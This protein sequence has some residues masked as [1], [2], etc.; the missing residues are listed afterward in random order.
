MTI[1]L[2]PLMGDFSESLYQLG[3]AEKESFLKIEE[4]V[5]H[6]I[7]K[8]FLLRHG[9]DLISRAK[10]MLKKKEEPTLFLQAVEAYAKGLG[11]DKVRYLSFLSMFEMAAHYGQAFPELKGMLPGCT[12][13]FQ[14]KDGDITHTRLFDFPLVDLFET[15]SRLYYWKFEGMPQVLNFSCEGLAPLFIQAIHESGMSFSLHHKPGTS[16]HGDG[17]GI[18]QIIFETMF[19]AK[20][21]NDFRKGIKKRESITKWGLLFSEKSGGVFHLDIDGPSQRIESFNLNETTPLIFT[22]IPLQ[23]DEGKNIDSYMRF[24]HMRQEW[25]KKRLETSKLPILD[26]VTHVADDKDKGFL[27][28]CGT[29]ATVGA[30][31]INQTQGFIELK[32]GESALT[33][34][35]G[36]LRFNL[37]EVSQGH[38]SKAPEKMSAF[39]DAWKR[40]ARAQSY[41]DQDRLDFAYHELQ[42]AIELM[43]NL[44]WKDIFRFYLFHWDFMILQNP[45]ELSLV[46]KKLRKLALPPELQSQWRILCCRFELKLGLAM[47]S[48]KDLPEHDQALIQQEKDAPK[49]LWLTWMKLIYPRLEILDTFSPHQ[50]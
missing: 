34:S 36:I 4:R 2:V 29:L 12:S 8:N 25:L 7:S 46:Y 17:L 41:F 22:N 42:M 19:E 20:N 39:E 40:A 13:L 26:L 32:F 21:H 14:K 35:D 5:N 49:A 18:F 47:D 11:I 44:H 38:V 1:K 37:G 6:L 23:T 3:L 48:F 43:P 31:H 45:K 10:I 24:S 16:F 9:Q 28:P 50:K 30:Y 27:H 33:K 15:N